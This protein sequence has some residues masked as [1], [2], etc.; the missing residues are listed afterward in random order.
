MGRLVGI[1]ELGELVGMEGYIMLKA[2]VSDSWGSIP[3]TRG[4]QLR[5]VT[6]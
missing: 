6:I 4:T 5:L 2:L 1:G 3:G